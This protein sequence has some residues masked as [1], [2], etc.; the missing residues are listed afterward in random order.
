M[1]IRFV[2]P[3][4]TE[5]FFDL[6]KPMMTIGNLKDADIHLPQIGP[7]G[8]L[9]VVFIQ[10]N[11][12]FAQAHTGFLISDNERVSH[13]KLT[14]YQYVQMGL[15]KLYL[16]DGG[17]LLLD[18]NT[19]IY[20]DSSAFDDAFESK[21][22]VHAAALVKAS[23]AMKAVEITNK[24]VVPEP[25][26]LVDSVTI[27]ERKI[28]KPQPIK[29]SKTKSSRTSPAAQTSPKQNLKWLALGAVALVVVVLLVTGQGFNGE[30]K[31]L[32]E[33]SVQGVPMNEAV[34]AANEQNLDKLLKDF[35]RCFFKTQ[36]LIPNL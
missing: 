30:K 34:E 9:A 13:A 32:S 28:E 18:E 20:N 33:S 4:G 11:D 36:S 23:P 6:T 15:Y 14:Q 27:V 17:Q 3:Q 2:S 25:P 29:K 24:P 5:I 22:V 19:N 1:R 7:P 26:E 10:G 8:I 12:V 16:S 35:D 31:D 21:T